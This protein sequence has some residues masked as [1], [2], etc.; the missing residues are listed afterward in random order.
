MK[1]TSGA[2]ELAELSAGGRPLSCGSAARVL[3]PATLCGDFLLQ[4]SARFMAQ[5]RTQSRAAHTL[6]RAPIHCCRPPLCAP[7]LTYRAPGRRSLAELLQPGH[8]AAIKR[9]PTHCGRPLSHLLAT[10]RAGEL[11]KQTAASTSLAGPRLS[12]G[13]R[14]T[15]IRPPMFAHWPFNLLQIAAERQAGRYCSDLCE[16]MFRTGRASGPHGK[17][18]QRV[19]VPSGTSLLLLCSPAALKTFRG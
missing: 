13:A 17:G 16:R 19:S 12:S 2:G 6:A 1:Q 10:G 3:R 15:P 11:G 18:C 14:L 7:C 5:R 8:R 4:R 9:R